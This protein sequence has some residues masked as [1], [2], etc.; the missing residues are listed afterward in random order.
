[1]G[2]VS[3]PDYDDFIG[4]VSL[5]DLAD[6]G[7][8]WASHNLQLLQLKI[9]D[10]DLLKWEAYLEPKHEQITRVSALVYKLFRRLHAH[11]ARDPHTGAQALKLSLTWA[12]FT[13]QLPLETA[14]QAMWAQGLFDAKHDEKEPLRMT[15]A[16]AVW[17]C[18]PW[19]TL[20]EVDHLTHQQQLT[21][22]AH[23]SQRE[24]PNPTQSQRSIL[25]Y[26]AQGWFTPRSEYSRIYHH[27]GCED[28]E[29]AI[30]AVV[31]DFSLPWDE[32]I[33]FAQ[34]VPEKPRLQRQLEKL[35]DRPWC[36]N[37]KKYRK[38]GEMHHRKR[39]SS[40]IEHER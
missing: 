18:L 30:C 11:A 5:Q 8:P 27:D 34:K 6:D 15:E 4:E 33:D 23:I 29:G 9:V 36:T 14:L 31:D 10:S 20:A 37:T 1:M 12:C 24:P 25:S 39:L 28:D 2:W 32:I 7:A 3:R 35:E 38:F 22:T 19:P 21:H 13:F 40:W 17:M 26:S 16:D